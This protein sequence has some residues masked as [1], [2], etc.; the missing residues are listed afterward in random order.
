MLSSVALAQSSSSLAGRALDANG[1]PVNHPVVHLISDPAAHGSATWRYTLIGDNLGKF[2]QEGL[3]PGAYLVML[4]TDGQ[5]SDVLESI[6]LRAG[7]AAQIVLR[8]GLRRG[9]AT[10]TPSGST[11]LMAGRR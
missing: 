1:Q 11:V 10:V 2:A 8:P 3:A 4:S 6:H 7:E 9:Q 5:A